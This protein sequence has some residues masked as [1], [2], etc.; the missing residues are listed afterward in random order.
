M[1]HARTPLEDLPADWQ[2]TIRQLRRE[3]QQMRRQ[4]NEAREALAALA[5]KVAS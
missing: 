5:L 4:R 3:N 1:S 2:E